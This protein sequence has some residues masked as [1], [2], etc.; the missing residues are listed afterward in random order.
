MNISFEVE[1]EERLT[2]ALRAVAADTSDLRPSWRAVSDE[3][4]SILRSQFSTQGA[5]GPGGRWPARAKSTV[6][7][8]TAINRKGFAVLNEPLRRTDAMFRAL[9]T[10][11]APHGVYEEGAEEL[12]LGTTLPY[13]VIHQRGGGRIPQRKI[14]D[15]TERDTA[16]IRSILKR[17]L[18]EKIKDR[19]FDYVE[20]SAEIPF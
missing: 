18:V 8:Y 16:R 9:T 2:R 13:A 15:F 14:Y 7:R 17:G 6:D 5:R 1:G 11:G 10:R 4:Y 19:G 20:D 3:V 12:V